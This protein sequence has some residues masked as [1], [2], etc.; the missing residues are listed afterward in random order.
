MAANPLGI[1][2]RRLTAALAWRVRDAIEAERTATVELGK[3][4]VD[5]SVELTE[6]INRLEARVAELEKRG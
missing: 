4:F 5:A 3:T 2:K 1:L 6:R